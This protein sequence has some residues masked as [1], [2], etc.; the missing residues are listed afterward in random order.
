MP[1]LIVQERNGA[2]TDSETFLRQNESACVA[3]GIFIRPYEEK[4]REA[5]R[6]ICCDTGLW[7]N[8][9]ESLFT[10]REIF[11]DLFAKPYLDHE[12]EWALIAEDRGRVVGYLLGSICPN[13]DLVLM[14]SGFQTA[15]KMLGRFATGRYAKHPRS[16]RFIRWLL[17]SGFWEQPRHPA[18]AAHLHWEIEKNHRG[19][20]IARLFWMAYEKKL[21]AAGVKQC[22]GA[23]FSH[24][25]RQPEHVYARFGFSV[26]DRKRTTLF[27]PEI[28]EPVDVVCVQKVL[29]PAVN[30]NGNGHGPA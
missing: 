8:P 22:Y 6:R 1:G 10:D 27:E 12:P 18:S 14:H 11:A 24:P 2:E 26:F 17:T 16:R 30:G 21:R 7:G 20:G 9:I 28:S 15:M 19:K 5:V 3:G 25:G 4:D 13:F 23:F 29:Q